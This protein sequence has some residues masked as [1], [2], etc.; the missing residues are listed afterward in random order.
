M[1]KEN[2][3]TKCNAQ[4]TVKRAKINL[5]IDEQT[6]HYIPVTARI[7]VCSSC[8]NKEYGEKEK[9]RLRDLTNFYKKEAEIIEQQEEEQEQTE[10]KEES[11]A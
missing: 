11:I 9:T 10:E 4:T 6:N 3:C 1:K 5:M 2:I 7:Q 8:G